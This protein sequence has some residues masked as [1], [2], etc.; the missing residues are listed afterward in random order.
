MTAA[1]QTHERIDLLA[2]WLAKRLTP[3][4][5]QWLDEQTDR[6]RHADSS[7]ALATAIGLAPRRLG[8]A[9]LALT[10]AEAMEAVALRPGFDPSLWS[11]DQT[12]RSAFRARELRRR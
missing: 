1:D 7:A 5:L 4:Q 8:K 12:A 11:V 2:G 6:V 9:D 3:E 10:D